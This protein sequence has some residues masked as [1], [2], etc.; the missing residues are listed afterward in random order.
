M[1]VPRGD[2][3]I[4]GNEIYKLV[5]GAVIEESPS[6]L[7]TAYMPQVMKYVYETTGVPIAVVTARKPETLDVTSRWLEEHLDGIPFHAYIIDGPL[8]EDT[9]HLLSAHIFVDDRWKTIER[10]VDEIEYPVLYNR[11][12]NMGRPVELPVSRVR[13]LRDIIPLLNIW[14]HRGVMDWPDT[15]PYPKPN[16]ERNNKRYATIT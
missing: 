16:G 12:W 3:N 14:A 1:D 4:S 8:K 2:K 15:L 9:I 5:T 7:H 6:F 13:D 11:P 10:M